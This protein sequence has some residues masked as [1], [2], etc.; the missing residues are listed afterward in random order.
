MMNKKIEDLMYH[1]GLT[2]QGCWDEM[3]EYDRSAIEKFAKLIVLECVTVLDRAHEDARLQCNF[4]ESLLAL[5]K[6]FGKG[7][8]TYLR[9]QFGV[10][11]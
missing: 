4:D 6:C 11:E 7:H 5:L 9:E 8:A 3:D 2:A 10:E 1:A